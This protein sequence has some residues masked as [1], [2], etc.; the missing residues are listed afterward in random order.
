MITFGYIL[1]L[2]GGNLDQGGGGGGGV[3][4]ISLLYNFFYFIF[5]NVILIN[6]ISQQDHNGQLNRR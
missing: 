3:L 6:N 5:V 2:H 1:A 4:K